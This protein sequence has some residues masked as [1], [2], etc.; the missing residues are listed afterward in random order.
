MGAAGMHESRRLAGVPRLD[1]VSFADCD[2][3]SRTLLSRST[4]TAW[5]ASF[6]VALASPVISSNSVSM[7]AAGISKV[8]TM[9]ENVARIEPM[10]FGDNGALARA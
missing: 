6:I 2:S 4:R 7:K 10:L 5:L 3:A 9:F 8:S 1:S